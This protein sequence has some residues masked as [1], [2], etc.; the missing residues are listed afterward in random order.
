MHQLMAAE[1]YKD[2]LELF[3]IIISWVSLAVVG[4]GIILNTLGLCF[5]AKLPCKTRFHHLLITL[6]TVDIFVLIDW[7]LIYPLVNV[8]EAYHHVH[9]LLYPYMRPLGTL[10]LTSSIYL[11]ISLALERYI[12]IANPYSLYKH[13][14]LNHARTRVSVRRVGS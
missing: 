10:F 14:W 1:K 7:I 3:R 9:L 2:H 8:S 5:L 11:T 13:P 4:A 12:S 6:V